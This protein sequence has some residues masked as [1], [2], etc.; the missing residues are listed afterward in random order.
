ML[1]DE[2]RFSNW[3]CHKF[4]K[5]CEFKFYIACDGALGLYD[6]NAFRLFGSKPEAGTS[7]RSVYHPM[8]LTTV[9]RWQCFDFG[10]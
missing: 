8:Q 1:S 9:D 2:P 6:Y 3:F 4:S 10:E 7:I 5:I